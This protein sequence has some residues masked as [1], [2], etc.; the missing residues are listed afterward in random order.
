MTDNVALI[1]KG[2]IAY[3]FDRGIICF[4]FGLVHRLTL[5]CGKEQLLI[6]AA[7]YMLLIAFKITFMHL[8]LYKC[9]ILS[10]I[11]I[12]EGFVI[13]SDNQATRL[14]ALIWLFLS[15]K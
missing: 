14:W 13:N 15:Y 9:K 4:L 12:F 3:T 11:N 2:M 6:L 1:M 5:F 7:V 10:W 8:N